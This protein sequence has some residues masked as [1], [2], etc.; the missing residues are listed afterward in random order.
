MLIGEEKTSTNN[1]L[2]ERI[3]KYFFCNVKVINPEI[4]FYGDNKQTENLQKTREYTVI[5]IQK[6]T[7]IY[8]NFQ[9]TIF[10]Q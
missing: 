2:I 6:C 10:L 8:I 4:G 9:I 1:T 3:E 5:Y 7:N